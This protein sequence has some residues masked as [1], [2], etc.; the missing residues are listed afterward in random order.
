[1]AQRLRAKNIHVIPGQLFCRQFKAKFL[2]ETKTYFIDDKDKVKSV[3]DTNNEFTECQP[4][5][6]K[7]Q[8]VGI[9][10]VSLH[11]VP[12][13]SRITNIKIKL[14]KVMNTLKSDI[15]EA[16][17][18]HVDCLED[19]GS[20][21]YDKKDMKVKANELVRSDEAIKNSIIFRSNPNSYL[22]T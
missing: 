15:S 13:H 7:L 21:S 4:P 16:Y 6:K 2:L 3:T 9:S 22:G 8:Q 10:S 1:M 12:Q 20:D 17:T 19:S 18:V 14:D 11:P 5:R